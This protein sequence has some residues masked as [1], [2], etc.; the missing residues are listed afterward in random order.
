MEPM[1]RIRADFNTLDSAPED[2]VK[3]AAP[4][5]WQEQELPP[6][7]QGERVVLYDYDGLEVEATVIHDE[8][9][10]WLAA[11]D[12]STW[13]DTTPQATPLPPVGTAR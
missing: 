8:A 13:R 11:P 7:Q 1:K 10:W 6:L 5:S 4:G 9:G 2:L 3:L 12:G